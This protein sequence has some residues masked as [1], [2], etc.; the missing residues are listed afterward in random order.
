MLVWCSLAKE[1]GVVGS[2]G[3][4]DRQNFRDIE[5]HLLRLD[6]CWLTFRACL[7]V[8]FNLLISRGKVLSSIGCLVMVAAQLNAFKASSNYHMLPWL[9]GNKTVSCFF[10]TLKLWKFIFFSFPSFFVLS[11]SFFSIFL[12]FFFLILLIS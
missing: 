12:I 8:C 7:L 6:C 1:T 2:V 9:P 3:L 10:P 4:G 5:V 11:F